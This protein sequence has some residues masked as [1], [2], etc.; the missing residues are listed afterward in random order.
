M[1]ILSVFDGI[2]CGQIALNKA[3]IKYDSGK[4]MP[5]WYADAWKL[6]PKER[7]M[8]RSKT[9]PGIAKALANQYGGLL[10]TD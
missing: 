8:M 9:F 10:L 4:S 7:A 3:G 5:S 2:S 6:P 1:N